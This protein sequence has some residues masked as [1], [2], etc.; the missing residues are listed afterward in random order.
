MV[1]R[2]FGV[3]CT[4][5]RGA[6]KG[7]RGQRGMH[8]FHGHEEDTGGDFVVGSIRQALEE[9]PP[10]LNLTPDLEGRPQSRSSARGCFQ[11]VLLR[12]HNLPSARRS[13]T[14]IIL[15]HIT[16]NKSRSARPHRCGRTY[17]NSFAVVRRES[18]GI[19]V[20]RAPVRQPKSNLAQLYSTKAGFRMRCWACS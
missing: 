5:F 19:A 12:R 20:S 9:G 3:G 16:P 6:T 18:N 8:T 4:S 15:S 11:R 17:A 1:L 14:R 2:Q 13:H 7:G 10:P